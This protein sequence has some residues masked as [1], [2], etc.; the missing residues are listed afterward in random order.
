[1]FGSFWLLAQSYARPLPAFEAP[2][3]GTWGRWVG[4]RVWATAISDDGLVVGY[5]LTAAGEAHAFVWTAARG[6]LDIGTLGGASSVAT[7]V[8][9]AGR[10]VG[11]A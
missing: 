8:D 4:A 9:G 3:S 5:S 1:R 2:P 6:M 10:V 7:G 11:D